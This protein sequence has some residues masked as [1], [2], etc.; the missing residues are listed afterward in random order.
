MHGDGARGTGELCLLRVAREPAAA[1]CCSVL[2]ALPA[3][4]EEEEEKQEEGYGAVAAPAQPLAGCFSGM[5]TEICRVCVC[6]PLPALP[7]ALGRQGERD[8][9]G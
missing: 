5:S 2:S 6:V 4:E 9:V 7:P 8:L 1:P 3:A